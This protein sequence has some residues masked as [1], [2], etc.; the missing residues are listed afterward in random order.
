MAYRNDHD[1]RTARC[2]DLERRLAELRERKT[3]WHTL[4]AAIAELEKELVV[5]RS[6][7]HRQTLPVLDNV[8]IAAPCNMSW[9]AMKGDERV[10]F[11][12]KC[13]KHVYNLS[14][15]TRQEGEQ[16]VRDKEGSLCVRFYQRV[17]GTV[18]SSDCP[19]GKRRL[20]FRRLAVATAGASLLL[21]GFVGFVGFGMTRMGAVCPVMPMGTAVVAAPVD[22]PPPPCMGE[23]A[24]LTMM[25]GVALP[26][27]TMGQI[28]IAPEPTHRPKHKL[29]VLK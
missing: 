4:D 6:I 28:R 10:R 9:D 20:R 5:E 11:C 23:P 16:L 18:L 25:G 26:P 12:G 27:S 17:D 1:A 29:R 14:N 24:P 2:F 7:L 13:E 19:V 15:M 21:F 22:D 8:R 3:Q